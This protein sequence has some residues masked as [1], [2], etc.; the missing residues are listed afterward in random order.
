MPHLACTILAVV[1]TLVTLKIYESKGY[2]EHNRKVSFNALIT[3]LN[4]VL[5]L[6]FLVSIQ[7]SVKGTLSNQP[8]I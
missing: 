5:A 2:V 4:I 1:I 8:N 7:P 3:V 6:N